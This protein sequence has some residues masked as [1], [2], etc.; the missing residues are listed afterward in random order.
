MGH[1][2]TVL[3]NPPLWNAYAP[4]LAVPLLVGT[5][6]ARGYPAVGYDLSITCLD[7]LLSPVV[8]KE[9][10][11]KADQTKPATL[12]E[13]W[14]RQR[15]LLVAQHAIDTISEAKASLRSLDAVRDERTQRSNSILLKTG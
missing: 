3:V 8:L 14:I 5:L 11:D 7:W 10:R 9:L 6:R 13:E 2:T 1:P 15:G 12:E 4:H